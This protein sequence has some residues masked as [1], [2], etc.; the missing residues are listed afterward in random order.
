MA[1][2][3]V[4]ARAPV[5]GQVKTRLGR[6]IGDQAALALYRAFVDDTC[7]MSAG[8]GARRVL[9]VAGEP[10]AWLEK[11]A[12]SQRMELKQQGEG[13]LG[14]RMQQAM[15][16]YAARGPVCIIGTDAPT[17]PRAHL[18]TALDALVEHEVVLGPADDGGY[19]LVGAQR[20]VP[21]LFADV[22]WSTPGVLAATL[23][24]LAGRDVFTLPGWYDVDEAHDLDRLRAELAGL[25]VVV[26]P[27]TRRALLVL[28]SAA[29]GEP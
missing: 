3:V 11:L 19:Y 26:A 25:P 9:A 1:T 29:K 16:E 15:A 10:D 28:G 5:L 27:A 18:H 14:A 21:E 12:K 20:S 17:L 23:R 13:D 22:P 4:F 7:L 6:L 2:L 8:L 24:N